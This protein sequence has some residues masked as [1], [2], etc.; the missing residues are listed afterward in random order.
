MVTSLYDKKEGGQVPEKNKRKQSLETMVRNI[1]KKTH[2]DKRV[3]SYFH[4][5]GINNASIDKFRLGI[6]K[7]GGYD[8]FVI[9]VLDKTGKVAYLK[10]RITPNDEPAETLSEVIFSLTSK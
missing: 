2:E 6:W 1:Y 10:L 3:R 8:R 9:P 7:F 5:R 4:Q